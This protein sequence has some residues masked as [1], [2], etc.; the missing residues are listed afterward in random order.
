M[1]RKEKTSEQI[2]NKL[3]FMS[4]QQEED[5]QTAKIGIGE[6]AY[7]NKRKNNK[8]NETRQ[9]EMNK[10]NIYISQVKLHRVIQMRVVKL[11]SSLSREIYTGWKKLK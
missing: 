3:Q 10:N 9:N 7:K 2:I 1:D 6:R 5:Q 11:M 8:R 4:C